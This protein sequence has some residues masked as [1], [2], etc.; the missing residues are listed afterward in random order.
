MRESRYGPTLGKP[1]GQG[2]DVTLL[3]AANL[4]LTKCSTHLSV[5]SISSDEVGFTGVKQMLDVL[6]SV[7]AIS[8][9]SNV[10][11]KISLLRTVDELVGT[12]AGKPVGDAVGLMQVTLP[13]SLQSVT[14]SFFLDDVIRKPT[15]IGY[16]GRRMRVRTG[17][18]RLR[19]AMTVSY[20]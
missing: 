8:G 17:A 20:S 18:T 15:S 14:K 4:S 1:E 2:T 12:T 9:V 11:A 6:P 7:F 13:P 3:E 16:G 19:A 10:T 5:L